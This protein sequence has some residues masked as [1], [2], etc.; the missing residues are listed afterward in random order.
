MITPP[1][2]LLDEESFSRLSAVLDS[3]IDSNIRLPRVPFRD[4]LKPHGFEEFDWIMSG[5]FWPVLQKLAHQSEDH[6]IIMSVLEPDPASYFKAMFGYYNWAV[7]PVSLSID[8]YWNFLNNPPN[9]SPADSILGNAQVIA[10]TAPS[11]LWAVWGERDSNVCVL[12]TSINDKL[13]AWH[14]FGWLSALHQNKEWKDFSRD[15]AQQFELS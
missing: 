2:F 12:A 8:D 11:K 4:S 9:D 1:Y 15:I 13:P 14:D 5:A 3:I 10:F 6:E 7:L